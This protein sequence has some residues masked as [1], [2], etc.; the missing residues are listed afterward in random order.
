MLD[1]DVQIDILRQIKALSQRLMA[2]DDAFM[3]GPYEQ[4]LGRIDATLQILST[5]LL[6][7]HVPDVLSGLTHSG[8]T[9]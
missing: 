4:L 9:P 7:Q 2:T 8:A 5:D 6:D 3:I 1:L